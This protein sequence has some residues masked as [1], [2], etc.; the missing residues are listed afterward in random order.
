[1]YVLLVCLQQL[2]GGANPIDAVYVDI[3]NPDGLIHNVKMV[4][5]W[6]IQER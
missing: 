1:M 5:R 6:G 3:K 4:P 2:V